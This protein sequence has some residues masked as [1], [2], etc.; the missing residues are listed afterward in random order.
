MVWFIVVRNIESNRLEL[1]GPNSDFDPE[2]SRYDNWVHI[3]PFKTE[4]DPLHLDFGVHELH[5]AC[6]CHPKLTEMPCGQRIY[7]HTAVVN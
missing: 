6:A 1:V 7:S 2:D 4:P 3:V 5:D